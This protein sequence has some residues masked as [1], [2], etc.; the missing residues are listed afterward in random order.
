ML[1]RIWFATYY[2]VLGTLLIAFI[3][4][5]LDLFHLPELKKKTRRI[6]VVCHLLWCMLVFVIVIMMLQN[7]GNPAVLII[8]LVTAFIA[9]AAYL[10]VL[11][12]RDSEKR[13]ELYI[14]ARDERIVA[15]A[16]KASYSA[17]NVTRLLLLAFAALLVFAPFEDVRA[18]AGGILGIVL[19]SFMVSSVLYSRFDKRD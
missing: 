16:H 13:K 1:R 11:M 19:V 12:L 6:M 2:V 17:L 3:G 4:T 10:V 18:I 15:N 9:L 7:Y 8:A 14:L 5:H